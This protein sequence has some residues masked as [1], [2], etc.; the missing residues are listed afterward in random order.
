ML[1]VDNETKKCVMTRYG[2]NE[3]AITRIPCSPGCTEGKR[4][5]KEKETKVRKSQAQMNKGPYVP[6]LV[7]EVEEDVEE[8]VEEEVR[9]GVEEEPGSADPGG[10]ED[11]SSGDDV[12]GLLSVGVGVGVGSV[13]VGSGVLVVSGGLDVSVSV[14]SLV[15][16]SVVSGSL[17]GVVVVV[18]SSGGSGSEVELL[19]FWRF[20]IC[21]REL[22]RAALS[23]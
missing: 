19:L 15:G 21:A 6:G 10:G 20:A 4:D 13:V 11:G 5:T 8:E 23:P 12:P 1:L 2:S 7:D 17:V 3:S 9:G 18:V 14:G 22:A 16:S